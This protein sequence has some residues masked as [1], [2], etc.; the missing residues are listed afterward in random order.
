MM[1]AV[2]LTFLAVFCLILAVSLFFVQSKD[3]PQALLKKRLTR[4]ARENDSTMPADVKRELLKESSPF[5]KMLFSIPAA[6]GLDRLID[7]AG[8]KI[9]VTRF[10]LMVIGLFFAVLLVGLVFKVKILLLL[11]PLFLVPA[12]PFLYLYYKRK[13][14]VERFME[15]LPDAL[16]MLGRSIRAGHSLSGGVELVGNELSAPLG[17]LFKNAFEQQKLGLS[18]SDALSNMNDRIDSIDLRFL[19]TAVSINSSVGGNLAE[20]LDKLAETIRERL[21]IRRQVQVYTAQGRMS[22]YVLGALPIA[23]FFLFNFMMPGYE[24][25]LFKE[26]LGN[27]MLMVALVLQVIGFFVIRKIINIRI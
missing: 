21:R 24:E 7:H 6:R 20:V 9:K 23:A 22:G 3:S 4:L 14:R 19:T 13:Q 16:T 18:I 15:Q 2:L 8:L 17:E 11:V 26:K 10:V 5:E 1:P 25:L 12:L 27:I